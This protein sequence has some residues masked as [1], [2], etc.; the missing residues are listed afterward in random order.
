MHADVKHRPIWLGQSCKSSSNE[1]AV[2]PV[3]HTVDPQQL[4]GRQASHTHAKAGGVAGRAVQID[5]QARGRR[6]NERS[7]EF[8]GKNRG[9]IERPSVPTSMALEQFPSAF[10]QMTVLLGY[11]MPAV[12]TR[13]Q[14]R[15]SEDAPTA[16]P[17]DLPS[18]DGR[19]WRELSGHVSTNMWS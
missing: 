7:A 5:E 10:E 18:G 4:V 8:A 16:Q 12:L 14:D 13:D 9:D 11:V 1:L 2:R 3:V 19:P 17:L 15:E 6:C